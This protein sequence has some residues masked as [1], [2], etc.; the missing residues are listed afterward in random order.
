VDRGGIAARMW[1]LAEDGV[2]SAQD[3]VGCQRV[4]GRKF[5]NCELGDKRCTRRLVQVARQ[6]AEHPDGSTPD[7][8][9]SWGDLKAIDRLFGDTMETDF[10]IHRSTTGL[11][12]TGDGFGRG[13]FLQSSL[14]A[15]ASTEEIPGLA[16]QEIFYRKP[17]PKKENSYQASQ[18]SRESETWGRVVDLI[19]PPTSNV[20][21]VHVFDRGAE[22]EKSSVI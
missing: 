8:A 13:F 6:M 19:G 20:K 21:Y 15:D 7:Q 5:P 12:P 16:G 14:M 17:A 2:G 10:G 18:R 11:G 1:K 3:D 9:E 4:G 22:I